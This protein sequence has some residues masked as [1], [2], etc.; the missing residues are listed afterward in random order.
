MRG[1]RTRKVG[2]RGDYKILVIVCEGETEIQ[3]F[4]RYRTRG[5]GLKIETPNTSVTDPI[6]LVQFAKRQI[7]RYGLNL[8]KDDYIW[9]VFDCDHNKAEAI[10]KAIKI[11]NENNINFA[12][13]NPSFELWFLLHFIYH[14]SKLSNRELIEKLK[15]HI[16]TYKKSKDVFDVLLK[17]REEAISN[18]KKLNEFQN[19]NEKEIIK[20]PSTHVFKLVELILEITN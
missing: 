4:N 6:N 18:A 13:S 2:G 7:N 9:V 11:A 5:C 20:N 15:T 1:Y 8:Q 14:H 3:Y 17:K 16:P 10:T 12:I 19:N